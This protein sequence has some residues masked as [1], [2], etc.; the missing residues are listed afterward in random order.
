MV[1]EGLAALVVDTNIVFS[2]LQKEGITR[3]LFFFLGVEFYTPNFLMV[4]I[5]KYKEKI[6]SLSTMNESEFISVVYKVFNK[7]NF[8][9]ET[10]IS[11]ENRKK[12]Y[13]MCKDIDETDT[14]FVALAL[15]LNIPLWSGDKKLVKGLKIK[16]FNKVLTTNDI[17]NICGSFS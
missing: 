2:I 15:E 5:I 10:L 11:A 14:P 7:I 13:E 4:E 17:K 9:N 16:E 1:P 3:K 8:V 12:A 6:V